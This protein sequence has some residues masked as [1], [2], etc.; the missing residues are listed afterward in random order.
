MKAY[1]FK[2]KDKDEK[3]HSLKDFKTKFTVL[4]FYPKDDTEG[5]T[6]E[7]MDFTK[8][9]GA[10]KKLGVYVVGIS[11]GNEKTKKS[12]CSKYN[13][14]VLLLSDPKFS[15]CK[16]YGVY[17]QKVFM[18]K[19]YMGIYRTTF[20]LDKNHKVIKVYK[21]IKALGHVKDVLAYIKGGRK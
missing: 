11:G 5:C 15:V 4:Y 20:V 6:I 3:F 9:L 10:F 7:A 1:D 12:F 2:L 14:K 13:L 19:K 17:G 18:G 16:R 8:Y 21:N